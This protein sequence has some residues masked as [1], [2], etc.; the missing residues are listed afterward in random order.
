M[1]RSLS[2]YFTSLRCSGKSSALLAPVSFNRLVADKSRLSGQPDGEQTRR[3]LVF[4]LVRRT[5]KTPGEM[6]IVQDA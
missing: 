4:F 6:E 2:L 3:Y 1:F 5:K